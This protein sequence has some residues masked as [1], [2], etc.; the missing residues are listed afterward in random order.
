MT[1]QSFSQIQQGQINTLQGEISR[2]IEKLESIKDTYEMELD[3]KNQQLTS[4]KS[5][6]RQQLKTMQ[7][8]MR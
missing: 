6:A 5:L 8:T 7:Q 1:V 3:Q 2:M 4:T